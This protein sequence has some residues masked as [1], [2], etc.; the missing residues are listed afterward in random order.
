MAGHCWALVGPRPQRRG[1]TARNGSRPERPRGGGAGP[2]PGL[3]S[4]CRPRPQRTAW[5][6]C[7]HGHHAAGAGGGTTTGSSSTSNLRCGLHQQNKRRVVILLGKETKEVAHPNSG[8]SVRWQLRLGGGTR[9]RWAAE[10]V[11]GCSLVQPARF[12]G[13]CCSLE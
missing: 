11:A 8:S 1:L 12:V 7:V 5:A 2:S 10:E 9:W 13:P 3:E 6:R 4:A